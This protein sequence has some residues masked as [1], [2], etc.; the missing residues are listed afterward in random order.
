MSKVAHPDKSLMRVGKLLRVL[1]KAGLSDELLDRPVNDL[2]FRQ[3]LVDFWIRQNVSQEKSE[4]VTHETAREIMGQNIRDINSVG[5]HFKIRECMELDAF[6]EI[7]FSEETLRECKNNH[8]LVADLGLSIFE[9]RKRVDHKLFYSHE[10]DWGNDAR[11]VEETAIPCW[12]LIRKEMVPDSTNKTWQEQCQLLTGDEE[13]P[14]A[15]VMVYTIIL[16]YLATGERMFECVNV[17]TSTVDS[18]GDH[19]D[20]GRFDLTG[21]GV[22]SYGG[23]YRHNILAVTSSRR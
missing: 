12:R 5:I 4:S 2:V 23:A 19:I 1:R 11:F 3:A 18:N 10:D 14:S 8:I 15:R 20:V 6:T 9:I 21:L 7:P 22:T 17:R 13:V 16:N